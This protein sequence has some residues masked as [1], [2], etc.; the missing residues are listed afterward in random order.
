MLIME[1]DLHSWF[2]KT[3]NLYQKN[4]EFKNN[5]EI[6]R[7]VLSAFIRKLAEIGMTDSDGWNKLLYIASQLSDR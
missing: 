6:E 4:A 7:A 1:E 5:E 3:C 2:T